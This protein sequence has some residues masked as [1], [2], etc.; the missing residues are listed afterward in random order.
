M[1]VASARWIHIELDQRKMGYKFF[2]YLMILHYL[3]DL[4]Y[5]NINSTELYED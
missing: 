3:Y 4:D 1:G 5:S 2:R